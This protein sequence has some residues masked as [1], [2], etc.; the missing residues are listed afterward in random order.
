MKI[1]F[2]LTSHA[3]LGDTGE[4]TGFWVEEFAAPYY[5]LKDKGVEITIASPAGGQAPIDP[6]SKEEDFRTPATERYEKDDEL[7]A[8]VANTAP[9]GSISASD[10]DAV[11][12]PGGHGPMWDLAEDTNSISLVQDFIKQNK[13]VAAVCH[14]P[15]IFKHTKGQDGRFLVMDRELTAFTNE[16]EEQVGLKDVVP[17]LL[18][19]ML[20]RNG[21][22]F[23]KG[24]AWQ[25][26]V[27][28]D[29][30]LITGQNPASSK[31][32]AEVLYQ[33]LS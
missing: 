18:E 17:F 26:H 33:S 23:K 1:L 15:A 19:D 25:E 22:E 29:G 7:Q 2:V 28:K 27:V 9:L 11:F 10:F 24:D 13:P 3:A 6:K 5:F 16:E 32:A 8:L 21:A 31:K 12:Y 14:A 4:K 20:V 30:L